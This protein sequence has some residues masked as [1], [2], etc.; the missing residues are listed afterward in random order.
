MNFRF[1]SVAVIGLVL[2]ANSI[3]N[4][5]SAGLITSSGTGYGSALNNSDYGQSFISIDKYI[6]SI[7][8]YVGDW[9]NHQNTPFELRVT[10]FNS[11]DWSGNSIFDKSFELPMHYAGWNGMWYTFNLD[12]ISVT[13]GNNYAFKVSST[14]GNGG[15]YYSSSN[16][17]SYG[18]LIESWDATNPDNIVTVPAGFNALGDLAFIVEG[19]NTLQQVPEPTT[20]AIFALGI[21]GLVS[22]RFKIKS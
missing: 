15:I 16:G 11:A 12:G 13:Q 19:S 3:F 4:V 17:Y 2:S 9:N 8:V 14:Y 5:S 20:L 22:R 10:L 7:S 18:N 21:M 6:N 1:F